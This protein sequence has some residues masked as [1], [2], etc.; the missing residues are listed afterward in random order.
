[1]HL[2]ISQYGRKQDVS[3]DFKSFSSISC[4]GRAIGIKQ[5][6]IPDIIAILILLPKLKF[7]KLQKIKLSIVA[8]QYVN[9]IVSSSVH[10]ITI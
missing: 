10:L 9:D 3:G 1:M 2:N 8:V 6:P 7:G 5:D 4:L